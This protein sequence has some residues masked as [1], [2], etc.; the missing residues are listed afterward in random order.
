MTDTPTCLEWLSANLPDAL[1]DAKPKK[2]INKAGIVPLV[3]DKT[4]QILLIKPR[5]KKKDLG[6]PSWQL[7]KGTRMV[8]TDSGWQDFKPIDKRVDESLL[9]PMLCAALRE[10]IE[11]A[12]LQLDNIAS[13]GSLGVFDFISATNGDKKSMELFALLI[14]DKQAF[15]WPGE[16]HAHTIDVKW[17]DI[18]NLPD[19]MRPDAKVIVEQIRQKL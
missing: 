9:E 16:N 3:E 6:P 8:Q 15:D 11:E 19:D 10:G 17:F 13:L 7:V 12:G 14:K 2:H 18:H 5:P 1:A 4:V